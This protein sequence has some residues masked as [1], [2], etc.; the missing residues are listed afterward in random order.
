LTHAV[1]RPW[2]LSVI[3]AAQFAGT[4]LWF[5]GNAILPDIQAAWQLPAHAVGTVTS[6]VQAGFITGTLVFALT[7][8]ADRFSPRRVFLV[9]ALLGAA[10][11]LGP[12]CGLTGMTALLICRFAVGFFLAGIYPVGMKIAAAAFPQSMG[13]AIGYLVGALVLGTAFPH[14][15]R[16]LDLAASWRGVLVTI[17]LLAALGGIALFYFVGDPPQMARSSRFTPRVLLTMFR[18]EEFRASAF[19]YFGHAW[20]LYAFWAFVPIL[21][22]ARMALPTSDRQ[23]SLWS[24]AVIGIGALGC[25][26]AARW[27]RSAGSARPALVALSLSGCCCLLSPLMFRLP[28]PLFF[29]ALLIWGMA[30]IADS[31]QFSALSA[32]F[33][34]PEQLGSSLTLTVC[35]GFSITIAAIETVG[36]G[37]RFLSPDLVLLLLLPGPILGLLAAWPLWRTG[38]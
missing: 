18:D 4:S 24:F 27:S 21:I 6:A 20:E 13:K 36:L 28:L 38:V 32:R 2:T 11:N 3:V 14:L 23:V 34:A 17:S 33:A 31:A 30:V 22:A 12:L 10:L 26:I 15:V 7:M 16:A 25:V 37:A 35:I 29:A 9:C 1:P 8:V 19:G 5:A